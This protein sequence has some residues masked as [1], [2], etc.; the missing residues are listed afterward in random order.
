M[1]A[2]YCSLT[3]DEEEDSFGT[4]VVM[5]ALRGRGF[6][7]E[8]EDEADFELERVIPVFIEGVASGVG[9]EARR[10]PSGTASRAFLG[11]RRDVRPPP[12]R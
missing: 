11:S 10:F 7:E 4:N 12:G 9:V 3:I 8:P 2:G 1:S 6:D 5:Y